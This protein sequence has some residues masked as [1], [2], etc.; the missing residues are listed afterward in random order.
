[1]MHRKYFSTYDFATALAIGVLALNSTAAF[2][3]PRLAT[4]QVEIV[5]DAMCCAG[6]ARKVS[7]QLYAT[8]GVKEVGVDMKSRTLTVSLPESTPA[9]L[10]QLWHA[11]EKGEGTPTKLVTAKATYTL[12]SPKVDPA[13]PQ[14]R[15]ASPLTIVIDNLHCQGCAKKIAAQIYTLKGVTKVSVDMKKGMLFVETHRD[16]QLSPWAL[17]DAV[18]KAKERPLAILG[19]HGELRV[20]YASKAAPKNHHQAQQPRNGGISR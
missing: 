8:R 20:K 15:V 6:C 14:P 2:A 5:D 18:S 13:N 11:V 3:A 7:G 9:M 17:I 4:T 19:N 10:G 1:M 16:L 12:V